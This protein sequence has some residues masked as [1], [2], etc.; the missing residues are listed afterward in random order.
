MVTRVLSGVLMLPLLAIIWFGG[1]PLYIL[2]LLTTI[3]AIY[4]F[5]NALSNKDLEIYP[6]LGYGVAFIF[7]IKNLNLFTNINIVFCSTLF[8]V[9]GGFLISLLNKKNIKIFFVNLVGMFY[10][11]FGFDTIITIITKFEYGDIYVWLIFLIAILSDTMAYFT[12]KFF[13]KHKLA[14]IL[15]PKKTIEGSIGAIIFSM[16]GCLLFGQIFELNIQLMVILGLIGSIVSQCGDLLASFVKRKVEIKD[17]GNLIPGH[18]GILDR[19]DS[20]ILVSQFMYIVLF[21][22]NIF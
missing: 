5:T 22:I 8:I 13:G 2:G 9:I 4:E 6:L 3:V 19:F 18:G 10:V 11:I 21:L 17:Y 14:P 1:I 12:G 7:F 20:I 16:I 15:S